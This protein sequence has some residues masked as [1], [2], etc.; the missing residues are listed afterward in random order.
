MTEIR[1]H[2]TLSELCILIGIFPSSW[3]N[4]SDFTFCVRIGRFHVPRNKHVDG[5]ILVDSKRGL[6]IFS[7]V[8]FPYKF[9]SIALVNIIILKMKSPSKS[10]HQN[11]EGKLCHFTLSVSWKFIKFKITARDYKLCQKQF[12]SI[13]LIK[14]NLKVCR[15]ES[16]FKDSKTLLGSQWYKYFHSKAH[17]KIVKNKLWMF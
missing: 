14:I 8:N 17:K 3:I 4:N 2:E 6:L 13:V 9:R 11:I 12:S 10:F 5:S 16:S 7:W 15:V 1:K